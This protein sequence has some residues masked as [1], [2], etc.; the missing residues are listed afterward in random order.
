MLCCFDRVGDRVVPVEVESR[1]KAFVGH[2][3]LVLIL[4]LA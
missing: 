2:V 4:A 1:F 3:A